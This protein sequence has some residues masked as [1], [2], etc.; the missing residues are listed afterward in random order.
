MQRCNFIKT[1]KYAP[2][3]ML[4]YIC[5]GNSQIRLKFKINDTIL[6]IH[7]HLTDLSPLKFS[8][9]LTVFSVRSNLNFGRTLRAIR[10]PIILQLQVIINEAAFQKK[11]AICRRILTRAP[12]WIHEQ[13]SASFHQLLTWVPWKWNFAWKVRQ[14]SGA[15]RPYAYG[16]VRISSISA[17]LL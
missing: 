3:R 6:F 14:C 17:T 2:V 9:F 11:T 1:M 13:A 5:A 16:S 7:A 10:L 12:L 15:V 8:N 4:R